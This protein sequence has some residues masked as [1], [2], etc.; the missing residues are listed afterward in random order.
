MSTI[1]NPV[2]LTRIVNAAQAPN[3]NLQEIKNQFLPDVSRYHNH[4]LVF[5]S[6]RLSKSTLVSM[7][8]ITVQRWTTLNY[9]IHRTGGLISLGEVDGPNSDIVMPWDKLYL[10]HMEDPYVIHTLVLNAHYTNQHIIKKITQGGYSDIE[11]DADK[12]AQ[13]GKC[14][15]IFEPD[16]DRRTPCATCESCFQPLCPECV[17]AHDELLCAEEECQPTI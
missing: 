6:C 9:H 14:G 1:L 11:L 7:E 17:D 12:E 13:C 5:L 2:L 3:A 16:T 8:L 15:I 4:V 10:G